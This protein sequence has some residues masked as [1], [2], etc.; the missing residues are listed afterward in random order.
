MNVRK[1][2]SLRKRRGV[3]DFDDIWPRFGEGEE[4]L[5]G[6]SRMSFACSCQ[7]SFVSGFSFVSIE[8]W[9]K[10]L[11]LILNLVVKKVSFRV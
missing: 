9:V 7:N 2:V 5:K 3:G 6:G 10:V 4:G 11:R 1:S 8:V